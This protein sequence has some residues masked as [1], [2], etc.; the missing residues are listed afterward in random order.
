MPGLYHNG[1]RRR[2]QWLGRRSLADGLSL[3]YEQLLFTELR[4]VEV[5][6]T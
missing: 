2:T 1:G 6:P 5:G 3:V 4:T